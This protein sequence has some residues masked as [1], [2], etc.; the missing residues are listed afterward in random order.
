MLR[1]KWVW[2][3]FVLAV[4]IVAVV[5]FCGDGEEAPADTEGTT[6][7]LPVLRPTLTSPPRQPNVDEELP[8]PTT[9]AP[10]VEDETEVVSC[11]AAVLTHDYLTLL[12]EQATAMQE[13]S[14]QWDAREIRYRTAKDTTAEWVE[15]T[16]T[17]LAER[18]ALPFAISEEDE[19]T[20]DDWLDELED[21]ADSVYE[22]LTAPGRSTAVKRR[23]AVAHY[24]ELTYQVP[25][26]IVRC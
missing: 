6:A 4:I 17:V 1:R 12:E 22:W 3:G 13:T 16:K 20:I 7:T 23:E 19:D 26:V 15:T 25:Y 10:L 8:P 21:A 24:V 14:R 18:P 2:V 11:R 5:S 9:T